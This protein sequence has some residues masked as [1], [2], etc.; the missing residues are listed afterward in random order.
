MNMEY[1]KTFN[2]VRFVSFEFK[3]FLLI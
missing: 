1:K 2:F 3:F